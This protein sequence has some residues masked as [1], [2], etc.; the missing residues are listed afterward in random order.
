ML[1][2]TLLALILSS[3]NLLAQSPEAYNKIY[4]KAYLEISQKDF[5]RA[6]QIADSLYNI[7]ESPR[8]KAKSLMLSATLM[9]QSGEIKNAV[10]YALN[11]DQILLGSD[12][13]IW[14]AKIS[15]FLASQYRNLQLYNESKKYIDQTIE[16]VSQINDPRMVNQTMGFI[17]QEKAYYEIDQKNYNQSVINIAE[18]ENYFKLSGQTNDF[19]T[20]NNEQLLG[21]S[22]FHL[23]DY[24]KALFYYQ[25]SL[26]KL[27]KMSDNFLKALVLNGLAKTYLAKKDP[28]NAK[29]FIEEAQKLADESNYLNLKNEIYQTSQKY[30][31]LIKDLDNLELNKAKQD[32]VQEKI[33]VKSS[34][35]INDS[36]SGLKKKNDELA[37]DSNAKNMLLLT[38]ILVL[39]SGCAYFIFYKQRQKRSLNK[40]KQILKDFEQIKKDTVEDVTTDIVGSEKDAV[41]PENIGLPISEPSTLMTDITEKKIL[42]NL[43]KF[44]ES[45]LFTQN[46]ISLPYVAAYCGTNTKYLSYVVNT[47][48]KKDFKNYINELRVRYI[49]LKLK[50]NSNYQKY[51]ISTLAEEA[52]FSSQSKFA[53]AFKKITSVNPSEFLDHLK[54][55]QLNSL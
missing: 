13:Y 7:S 35:F 46:T 33:S 29:I 12:E 17:M 51:K 20:A 52:G 4:T 43:E 9:Q 2:I 16:T 48:K 19:L 25:H 41:S 22:Y 39:L 40:V 28:S 21:L 45:L 3:E 31:A 32:S 49:I 37:R 26:D 18:S 5:P 14:K 47:H 23:K 24:S 6:I 53:A 11:A 10:E 38:T 1:L 8:Y 42:Y 44:E 54:S 50:N 36:Y 15:G 34:A 27:G 55:Q 30:F